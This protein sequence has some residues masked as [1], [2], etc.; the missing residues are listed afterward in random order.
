MAVA[1]GAA[2]GARVSTRPQ[3]YF[4]MA[5]LCAVTAIGGFIPTFWAPM[6]Q[7]H[8][9]AAP[10]LAIHG[11]LFSTWTLFFVLQTWLAASGDI[12]NHRAAGLFG[13]AL[14]SVMFVFGLMAAIVEVRRAAAIGQLDG[15]LSFSILPVWHVTFFATLVAL[16]IANIRRPDWHKRLMLVASIVILDAPLARL[17]NYFVVFHGHIPVPAGLPPQP[18][19]LSGIA[20]WAYIVDLYLLFPMIY[21]WRT[22][23]RPHVVTAAGFGFV[24]LMELLEGPIGRTAAWH[25]FASWLVSLAG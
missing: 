16:A 17:F 11:L 18:H 8:Y 1:S 25:G 6:T 23:G 4:Y 21:D 2:V 13:I 14:A 19:V 20:P 12:A 7:G 9:V 10:I 3:F 5:L 15:G 22:R 24:V